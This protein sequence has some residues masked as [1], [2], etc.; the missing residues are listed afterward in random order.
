MSTRSSDSNGQVWVS[1][2]T[3]S[4]AGTKD[5]LNAHTRDLRRAADCA[6]SVTEASRASSAVLNFVYFVAHDEVAAVAVC[7]AWS[8]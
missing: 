3:P 8:E 6:N 5:L 4:K 1:K 7:R 2:W